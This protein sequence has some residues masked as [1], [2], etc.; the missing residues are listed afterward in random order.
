[1]LSS[2]PITPEGFYQA[3][4]DILRAYHFVVTPVGPAGNVIRILPGAG[5]L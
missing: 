5:A 2:A 1:M 4:L 3:F